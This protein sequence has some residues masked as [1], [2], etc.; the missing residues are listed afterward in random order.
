[1][2]TGLA[3]IIFN[4]NITHQLSGLFQS[5]RMKSFNIFLLLSLTLSVLCSCNSAN[6]TPDGFGTIDT[7]AIAADTLMQKAIENS[8]EYHATL[9]QNEKLVYDVIGW[10]ETYKGQLAIVRR[11]AD[12]RAD[13]LIVVERSGG[14]QKA[15]ITDLDADGGKEVLVALYNSSGKLDA[16]SGCEVLEPAS[17]LLLSF[18]NTNMLTSD[19]VWYNGTDALTI[20]RYGT[21]MA[22]V[23]LQNNRLQVSV[24]K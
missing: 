15:F 5:Q 1:M 23:F 17:P 6:Q 14:V 9:I 8:Y 11:A 19:S 13:T 24:N 3:L 12:N 10:G 22:N 4:G 20:I 2:I 18:K 21:L 16:I 7:Q